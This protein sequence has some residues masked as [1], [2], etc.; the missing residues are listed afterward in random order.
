VADIRKIKPSNGEPEQCYVIKT[1]FHLRA[2]EW[3][4]EIALINRADMSYLI[5]LGREGL[6]ELF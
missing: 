2:H 1:P 3:N 5:L 6:G 4:I